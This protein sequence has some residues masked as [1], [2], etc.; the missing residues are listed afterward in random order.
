ML[1]WMAQTYSK[2]TGCA[3]VRLK[4]PCGAIEPEPP[5]PDLG[6]TVWARL[7]RLVQVT[8]V[9]GGTVIVAS[10]AKLRMSV[11]RDAG[12]AAGG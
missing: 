1:E 7:S 3:K 9:P 6:V 2:R 11:A 5:P 12:A 8:T 4:A 10:K